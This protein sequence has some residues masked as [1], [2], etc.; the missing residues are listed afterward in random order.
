MHTTTKKSSPILPCQINLTHQ[1]YHIVN[2]FTR[3]KVSRFRTSQNLVINID[4]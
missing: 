4:K 2:P 3:R 1:S